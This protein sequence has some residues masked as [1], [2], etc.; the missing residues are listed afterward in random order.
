MGG[1][2]YGVDRAAVSDSALLDAQV[3]SRA[4]RARSDIPRRWPSGME[5]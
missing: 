1:E 4:K 5:S 2:G 3:R